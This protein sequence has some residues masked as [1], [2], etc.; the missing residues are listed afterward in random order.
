M[1]STREAKLASCFY[2]A[3]VD[4]NKISE[5]RYFIKKKRFIQLTVFGG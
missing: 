2:T 1:V 5:A 4:I 3:S